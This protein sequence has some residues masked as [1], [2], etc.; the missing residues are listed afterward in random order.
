MIK[1]CFVVTIYG[2]YKAFLKNFAEYLYKSGEYDIS[3]ICSAD[4]NT[5]SDIPKYIHYYPVHMARGINPKNSMQAIKYINHILRENKFDIIQYSTPNAAFYASLVSYKCRIPVRLYCQW[6][7]RYMGFQG[8]RRKL[9]KFIEKV[10]CSLSTVVEVESHG[11]RNFAISE[12]LYN[13][14]KSTVVGHGSACGVNLDKFNIDRRKEWRKEIRERFDINDTTAVLVFC[15]RI[16]GDK[17]INELL[18]AFF[19]ISKKTKDV[20]LMII[21]A[22]DDLTPDIDIRLMNKA[23]TSDNIIFTGAVNSVEKYFAASDIFVSPSY[24]EGFGLVVIE[25]SAMGL[26][27]IV[28]DVPGQIDAFIPDVTGLKCKVKDVND[29][30]RA[31]MQLINDKDFQNRGG[32]LG[33]KFVEDNFEQKELFKRLKYKRDKYAKSISNHTSL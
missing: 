21:G 7:I 20:K 23:K 3:L 22:T 29:L 31:T 6:G 27:V 13:R 15:A 19:D 30:T 11:I 26:P 33:R 5:F 1:I 9:F 17:G 28:T 16:T 14:K 8:L 32:A 18:Q 10:I 25:A 2:T 4:Y 12:G 24:R